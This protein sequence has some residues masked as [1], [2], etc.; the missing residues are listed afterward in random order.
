MN[1]GVGSEFDRGRAL[2]TL[3]GE[4]DLST[5]PEAEAA[6]MRLEHAPDTSTI[7]LD[8]RRLAFM[9][10]TGLRFVLAA[11]AR[12]SGNDRRFVIVRGPHNVHRVFRLAR[13]E[14]RLEFADSVAAIGETDA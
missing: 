8:L 13:L 3:H 6:M 1:L 4:L 5:V 10:S 7:V 2:L 9:D 11:G 12:A 14:D